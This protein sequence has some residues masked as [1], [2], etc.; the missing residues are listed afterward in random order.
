[1]LALTLLFLFPPKILF[2][3]FYFLVEN[4]VLREHTTYSNS[5]YS[6]LNTIALNVQIYSSQPTICEQ[7]ESADNRANVTLGFYFAIQLGIQEAKH[8]IFFYFII[9]A[10][11]SRDV[12]NCLHFAG[13]LQGIEATNPMYYKKKKKKA[14]TFPANIVQADLLQ[15]NLTLYLFLLLL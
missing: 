4:Y 2:L 10:S 3:S 9:I 6:C 1:M 13:C 15:R 8:I 11:S 5:Y 12:L 14:V 7:L